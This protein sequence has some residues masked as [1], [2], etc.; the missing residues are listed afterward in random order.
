MYNVIYVHF[1]QMM[2]HRVT[3]HTPHNTIGHTRT[4]ILRPLHTLD[5]GLVAISLRALSLVDG[6]TSC[7]LLL[8]STSL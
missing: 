3:R 6:S 1:S 8:L 5:K 4:E 7:S 2:D